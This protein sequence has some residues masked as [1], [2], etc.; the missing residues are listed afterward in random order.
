MLKHFKV[1]ARQAMVS[2]DGITHQGQLLNGD[3]AYLN[4]PNATT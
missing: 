1:V 3:L 2:P 4:E